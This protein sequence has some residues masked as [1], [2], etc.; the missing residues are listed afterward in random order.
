MCYCEGVDGVDGQK[1]CWILSLLIEWPFVLNFNWTHYFWKLFIAFR[2]FN[3]ETTALFGNVGMHLCTKLEAIS[4]GRNS[5]AFIYGLTWIQI[6][7]LPLVSMVTSQCSLFIKCFNFLLLCNQLPQ[8][9]SGL[10]QEQW[11]IVSWPLCVRNSGSAQQEWLVPCCLGPTW[12]AGRLGTERSG[13]GS[14]PR[15]GNWCC[16][17]AGDAAGAVG[18]IPTHSLVAGS[19]G[20]CPERVRKPG[21]SSI[22]LYVLTLGVT[23]CHLCH[24]FLLKAGLKLYMV[25]RRGIRLSSQ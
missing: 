4:Y 24:I 10:K 12:K 18:R 1:W 6:L 8:K 7:A 19:K 16:L 25:S 20:R 23:Q 22:A 2:T 11:F 17:L 21:G 3:L 5:V 15:S 9:L 13:E 14:S